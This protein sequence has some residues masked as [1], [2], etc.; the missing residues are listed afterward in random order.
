[1]ISSSTGTS[2][3]SR[4]GGGGSVA[5]PFSFGS[6]GKE[7]IYSSSCRRSVSRHRIDFQRIDV[8]MP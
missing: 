7:S 6:F 5:T 4:S 2:S 3:S 8:R 1:M